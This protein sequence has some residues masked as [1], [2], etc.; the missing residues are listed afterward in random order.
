MEILSAQVSKYGQDDEIDGLGS[1][2]YQV[3]A[4]FYDDERKFR[5]WNG[6][7]YMMFG[8]YAK[9]CSIQDVAAKD[10][11]YLKWIV[12]AKFSDE[13]KALVQDALIGKFPVKNSGNKSKDK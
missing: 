13:I 1:F 5:W 4:E 6:K 8:K 7:L 9:K 3:I 10:P 11:K 12:S 2:E